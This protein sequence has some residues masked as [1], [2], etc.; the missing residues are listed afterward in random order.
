MS[1][2]NLHDLSMFTAAV[3]YGRTAEFEADNRSSA[4]NPSTRGGVRSGATDQ[5]GR[6]AMSESSVVEHTTH[7]GDVKRATSATKQKFTESVCFLT[8]QTPWEK[9]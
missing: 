9:Q 2:H 1:Q 4:A 6:G 5:K 8:Q 7:A 3:K